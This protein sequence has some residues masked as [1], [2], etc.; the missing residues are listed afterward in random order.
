MERKREGGERERG[1]E[2][3][4]GRGRERDVG[5]EMTER[6]RLCMHLIN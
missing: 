4:G 6:N 3:E 5:D 2:G 1:G